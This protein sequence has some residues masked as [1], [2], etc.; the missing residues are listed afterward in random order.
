[1][2]RAFREPPSTE[3]GTRSPEPTSEPGTRNPEPGTVNDFA[4]KIATVNGTGS[5]SANGLL[6]H[7]IFRMG[8]PVC[9]KNVF[10]SNIQ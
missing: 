6:M 3:P 5:A 10:P 1:M 9:G 7:A 4:L 2:N 8:I